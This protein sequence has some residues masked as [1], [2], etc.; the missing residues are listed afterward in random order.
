MGGVCDGL[1]R[2]LR[3]VVGGGIMPPAMRGG[4]REFRDAVFEDVG[5][6]SNIRL[7]L[8]ISLYILI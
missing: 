7:I 6:E 3:H 1:V 5:F 4:F 8:I 2:F